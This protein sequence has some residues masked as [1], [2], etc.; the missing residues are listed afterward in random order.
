MR[1]CRS[2]RTAGLARLLFRAARRPGHRARL[3]GGLY[4]PGCYARAR[5]RCGYAWIRAHA[6][7]PVLPDEIAAF[8]MAMHEGRRGMAARAGFLRPA[9]GIRQ[10]QEHL[11]AWPDKCVSGGG[12]EHEASLHAVVLERLLVRS[13]RRPIQPQ[14]YTRVLRS[15]I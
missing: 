4:G 5:I 10:Q 6:H 7:C 12:D 8:A 2:A 13:R 15:H 11:I 1:A 14:R 3:R 9:A